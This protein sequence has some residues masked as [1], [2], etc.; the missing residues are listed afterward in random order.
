M[1]V[2][3]ANTTIAATPETIWAILTNATGYP[4]WDPGVERIEGQIAPGQKITAYTKL[5]P[6]RAFPVTVIEFE[7]GRKMTWASG[8]PLGL[9]KGE[10]TF[11]LSPRDAG[12]TEF[13]LREEFSG[14]LLGLIGRSIPD[15]TATFEQFAA[16][17]KRRA[18]RAG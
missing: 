11:T 2:Y 9:F 16:G 14:L 8:L 3:Q 10:R 7:P 1:K 6:G 4:E 18:E 17:L 15:M 5:S 12:A 13:R